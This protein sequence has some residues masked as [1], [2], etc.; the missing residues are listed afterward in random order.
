M[1]LE[2]KPVIEDYVKFTTM[3]MFKEPQTKRSMWFQ[4]AMLP[5]IAM[6]LTLLANPINWLN[7]GGAAALSALW[8]YIYPKLFKRMIRKRIENAFK[9][10]AINNE[11]FLMPYVVEKVDG[12]LKAT[13]NG[14]EFIALYDCLDM[15]ESD[16]DHLLLTGGGF[17]FIIPRR[18]F[19]SQADFENFKEQIDFA[20]Q[21]AI[22]K[23]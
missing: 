13:R 2:I 11:S 7:V 23:Q 12:G 16:D 1:R 5:I 8:I 3:A 22:K 17:D 19:D 21:V 18:I 6:L 15:Y 9:S 14:E 20:I 10:R 4:T